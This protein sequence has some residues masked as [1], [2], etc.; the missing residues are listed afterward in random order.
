MC[1]RESGDRRGTGG[2]VHGRSSIDDRGG[3]GGDGVHG[4][5]SIGDRG[6][7]VDE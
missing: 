3:T 4:K 2:G 5:S 6:G 1:N 7:G